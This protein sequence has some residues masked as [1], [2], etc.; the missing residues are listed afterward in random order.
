MKNGKRFLLILGMTLLL[1]GSLQIFHWFQESNDSKKLQDKL[2]TDAI[3][4]HVEQT[5]S[6]PFLS[7]DFSTLTS[8]NEDV[9]GWIK[10]QNTNVDYPIV[11]SFDNQF[12]LN[13]NFHKETSKAGWI[14]ADYRNPSSLSDQNIILYGH[15]RLDNSMFGSL[16]LLLEEDWFIQ[17]QSHQIQLSTLKENRLYEIVS[18]YTIKPETYY[19]TTFFENDQKWQQYLEAI[20]RRSIY[21]FDTT[22]YP[23]DQILTLSTCQD[24]N[25]N[26]LVVHAKLIKK[27]IRK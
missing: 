15:G 1:F 16:R 20:Q 5:E 11:Q 17:N 22:L 21:S 13:H 14:F 24:D 18:I 6:S 3:I 12:Y 25:Q 4:D 19:L 9:V 26:R 27:E 8:Q 7:I 2:K 23:D 10:I